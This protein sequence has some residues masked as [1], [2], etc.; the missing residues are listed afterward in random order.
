M[1]K[2]GREREGIRAEGERGTHASLLLSAQPAARAQSSDLDFL[3]RLRLAR[4]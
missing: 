4:H 3:G 2:E 1:G